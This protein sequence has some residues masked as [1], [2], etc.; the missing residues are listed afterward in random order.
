MILI[1]TWKPHIVLNVIIA[2]KSKKFM[3]IYVLDLF[4]YTVHTEFYFLN[5][6]KLF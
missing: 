5:I 3:M 4:E 6:N 2:E 1:N